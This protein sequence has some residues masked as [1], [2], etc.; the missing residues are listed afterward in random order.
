MNEARIGTDSSAEAVPD[1]L[2]LIDWEIDRLQQELRQKLAQR[3]AIE[4][5]ARSRETARE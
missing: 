5:A 2:T 3:D 1:E 4:A